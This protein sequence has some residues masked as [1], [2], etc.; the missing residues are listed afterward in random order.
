MYLHIYIVYFYTSFNLLSPQLQVKLSDHFPTSY[1]FPIKS[2][3]HLTAK[4][5][6]KNHIIIFLFEKHWL[7]HQYLYIKIHAL[8]TTALHSMELLCLW[9][10]LWLIRLLPHLLYSHQCILLKCASSSELKI[11]SSLYNSWYLEKQNHASL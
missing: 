5:I 11:W 8:E 2:A 9:S 10:H 6:S 1:C 3:W 4:L 7:V